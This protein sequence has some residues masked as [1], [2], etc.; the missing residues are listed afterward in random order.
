MPK[1][2]KG[3][4][5]NRARKRAEHYSVPITPA[6]SSKLKTAAGNRAN[7]APLLTQSDARPWGDN[8]G[9]NYHRLVADVVATIGVDPDAT[10]YCLR[11]S[12]IVRALPRNVPVRVIASL[13]NTSVRMIEAHYSK[14]ITEHADDVSRVGLL[15][16]ETPTGDNIVA[17]ESWPRLF[18]QRPAG[19]KWIPAGLC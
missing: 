13:H 3:G 5:R 18:G 17:L 4:G 11:H 8:P 16:D 7:D 1:S 12:S 2:G 6:L 14:Y 10:M 9:Q 15:Q 19:F